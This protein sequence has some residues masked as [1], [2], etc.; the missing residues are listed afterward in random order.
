VAQPLVGHDSNGPVIAPLDVTPGGSLALSANGASNAIVWA[1]APTDSGGRLLAF[2]ALTL[3]KLWE[4]PLPGVAHFIPPTIADG[5]VF[6]A[7]ADGHFRAYGL[8]T[9][10]RHT[11]VRSSASAP[12]PL[13][14][15]APRVAL[16]LRQVGRKAAALTPP[17]AVPLFVAPATGATTYVCRERPDAPGHWEWVARTTAE[18]LI[19]EVGTRPNVAYQGRGDTLANQVSAA[20]WEAHDGSRLHGDLQASVPAPAPDALPWQ[21]WKRDPASPTGAGLFAPVTYLLRLDTQGGMPTLPAD[22]ANAGKEVRVTYSALYV[23]Y[24]PK[25]R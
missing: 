22:S 16:L 21:L 25:R 4:E 23:V 11:V 10:G 12:A 1:T 8:A 2:D 19:D 20:T 6:I 24:G 13:G 18:M 9:T 14:S 15:P 7:T 17:D 3:R 5:T